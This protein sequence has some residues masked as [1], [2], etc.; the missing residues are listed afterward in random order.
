M[1]TKTTSSQFKSALPESHQN[2]TV[3]WHLLGYRTLMSNQ[4][5]TLQDISACLNLPE[6]QPVN[7]LH[8]PNQRFITW[9]SHRPTQARIRPGAVHYVLSISK[10]KISL[11]WHHSSNCK[12]TDHRHYHRQT[13]RV[14]L[15]H[16]VSSGWFR[17]IREGDLNCVWL[18]TAR[19]TSIMLNRQRIRWR[20]SLGM[21]N[22]CYWAIPIQI[23]APD[24]CY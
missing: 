9:S 14:K 20:S 15:D 10:L 11:R 2:M 6:T 5:W 8:P 21:H 12:T 3:Q 16:P 24:Y 17:N 1:L 19:R 23:L 18:A 13:T 22:L 7:H 4:C